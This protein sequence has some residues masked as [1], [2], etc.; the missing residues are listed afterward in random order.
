MGCVGGGEK[1]GWR[2]EERGGEMVVVV[3][4]YGGRLPAEK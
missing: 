4:G 1:G 3:V 2:W